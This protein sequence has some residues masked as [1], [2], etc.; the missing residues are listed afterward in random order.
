MSSQW[1]AFWHTELPI[2]SRRSGGSGTIWSDSFNPELHYAGRV[3][4]SRAVSQ[5]LEFLC[6]ARQEWLTSS[7]SRTGIPRDRF[8]G[9]NHSANP[10]IWVRRTLLYYMSDPSFFKV[11]EFRDHENWEALERDPPAAVHR[12]PS[13]AFCW[14]RLHAELTN[15]LKVIYAVGVKVAVESAFRAEW[16]VGVS[17]EFRSHDMELGFIRDAI[18]PGLVVSRVQLPWLLEETIFGGIVGFVLIMFR[19]CQFV[20]LG[21]LKDW[22]GLDIVWVPSLHFLESPWEL[23]ENVFEF[24]QQ[25]LSIFPDRKTKV[26]I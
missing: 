17:E 19:W 9:I 16:R 14:L 26:S 2:E 7:A 3:D 5:K 18:T 21:T 22:F 10:H 23:V 12:V 11:Y 25:G 6:D 15:V 24:A 4:G 13:S 8:S 1:V 20:F